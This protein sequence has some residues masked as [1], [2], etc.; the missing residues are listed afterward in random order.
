MWWSWLF[1]YNDTHFQRVSGFS[2][3]QCQLLPIKVNVKISNFLFSS[4]FESLA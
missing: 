1:V 4:L 2:S 3:D